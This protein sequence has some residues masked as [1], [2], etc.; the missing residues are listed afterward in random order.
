MF[1]KSQSDRSTEIEI[2]RRRCAN[3][4]VTMGML[5]IG[6]WSTS[7]Y[8]NLPHK[9]LMM[10]DIWRY[11]RDLLREVQLPSAWKPA[12][13]CQKGVSLPKMR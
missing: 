9:K 6:I 12:L 3:T 11:C 10:F 5:L 13:L 8:V 7:E 2:S 1:S 4:A